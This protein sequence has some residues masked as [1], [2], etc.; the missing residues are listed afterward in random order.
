M[1]KSYIEI[2][3]I[4]CCIILYTLIKVPLLKNLV[5][6]SEKNQILYYLISL[7]LLRFTLVMYFIKKIHDYNI[8]VS[9]PFFSF[10][11]KEKL[12]LIF[13]VLLYFMVVGCRVSEIIQHIPISTFLIFLIEKLSIGFF[14][15][16]SFRI[17]IIYFLLEIFDSKR[18]KV[19]LASVYSSILFGLAHLGH[20]ASTPHLFDVI[21]Y[22]IF[23]AGVGLS[24]CALLFRI[25]NIFIL[26]LLHAAIDFFYDIKIFSI[27]IHFSVYT[28]LHFS[29]SNWQTGVTHLILSI[30]FS[31]IGYF[32]LPK[33][34]NL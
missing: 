14:E 33:N 27:G 20:L 16:L 28:Q 30:L 23:T 25:Q 17:I 9:L 32:F 4:L 1:K 12:I 18:N 29:F 15:E 10:L 11:K 7:S 31:Y 3:K 8:H 5:F 22:S 2:I 21:T 24:F 6:I 19:L 13:P 34:I 26:V